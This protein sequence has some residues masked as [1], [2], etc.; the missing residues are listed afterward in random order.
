MSALQSQL[1]ALASGQE[2]QEEALEQDLK[3]PL[4]L[5]CGWRHG[6]VSPSL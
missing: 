5:K 3:R 4:G 6:A 2:P 1:E